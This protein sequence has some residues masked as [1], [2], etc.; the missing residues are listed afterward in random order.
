MYLIYNTNLTH[1]STLKVDA[2]NFKDKEYRNEYAQRHSRV[3][4]LQ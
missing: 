1:V 3:K 2:R 4:S